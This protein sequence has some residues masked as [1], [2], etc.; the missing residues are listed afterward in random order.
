MIPVAKKEPD[1]C[2]L[3]VFQGGIFQNALKKVEMRNE[4]ELR[5]GNG[6]KAAATSHN[7]STPERDLSTTCVMRCHQ[8]KMGSPYVVVAEAVPAGTTAHGLIEVSG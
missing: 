5:W 8:N 7:L 6:G 3:F 2:N 4:A 1:S